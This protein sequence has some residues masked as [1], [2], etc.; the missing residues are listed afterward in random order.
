VPYHPRIEHP[1]LATLCTIRSRNAQ[2]WFVNNHAL[3]QSILGYLARYVTRYQTTIYAFGIE[4]NHVHTLAHYALGTQSRFHRDLNSSI[5]R[6]IPRFV[7]EYDGGRFWARRYSSEFVPDYSDI[8]EYFFYIV[9]QPVKD[10]LVDSIF[11]YPGYNCFIDAIHE[12]TRLYQVIDWQ[13]YH[14]QKRFNRSLTPQ[15]FIENVELKFSRLPGYEHMSQK[16]YR[17]MMLKKLRERTNLLLSKR[18]GRPA[19]GLL[20]IKQTV[21]GSKPINSKKSTRFSH[22]PRILAVNKGRRVKWYAWYFSTYFQ[23]REASL[24]FRQGNLLVEFPP[25]THRPPSFTAQLNELRF[26]Q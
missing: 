13:K 2:L 4:G 19:A 24:E 23:Y 12:T 11:E 14:D 17:A 25:G 6:A 18:N 15:D 8:E 20:K 16:N 1:K 22:R 7:K 21:P 9:L 26:Q 3:E 5:A 10:G